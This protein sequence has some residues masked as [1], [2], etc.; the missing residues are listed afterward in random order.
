LK[1]SEEIPDDPFWQQQQSIAEDIKV[2][3]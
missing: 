2:A 1:D 3:V